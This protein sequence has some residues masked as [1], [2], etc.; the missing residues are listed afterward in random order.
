MINVQNISSKLASLPDQALKQY[1][2]MHKEDPYVFSLALSE[3][4]R[5]KQMR[6]QGQQAMPQ[7]RVVDKELEEMDMRL[8]EDLGIARIPIDMNMASGGIVAF[9]DGGMTSYDK[10]GTIRNAG[11]SNDSDAFKFAL[12]NTLKLEG[13]LNKNDKVGGLTKYGISQRAYPDLD[14]ANLTLADAK[15][16]YKKDYWNKIGGDQLAQKDPNLAALAFD[17]AVQHGV[18]GAQKMLAVSGNDPAKLLQVR[19]E[20]LKSLVEDNPE[21]YGKQAKGWS[22]R[23]SQLAFDLVP[24][25]TAVAGEMPRPAGN[26]AAPEGIAALAPSEVAATAPAQPAQPSA[27]ESSWRDFLPSFGGDKVSDQSLSDLVT[28]KPQSTPATTPEKS[29]LES[30]NEKAEYLMNPPKKS[31]VAYDPKTFRNPEA[32]AIQ[33]LYPELAIL[34]APGRMAAIAKRVLDTKPA[35]SGETTAGLPS[36]VPKPAPQEVPKPASQESPLA[37]RRDLKPSEREQMNMPPRGPSYPVGEEASTMNFLARQRLA[38]QGATKGAAQAEETSAAAAPTVVRN[39]PS[40]A[41]NIQTKMLSPSAGSTTAG[42]TT[43]VAPEEAFKPDYQPDTSRGY[44]SPA[45]DDRTKRDPANYKPEEKKQIIEAAKDAVPKSEDTDG[46]SKNDWLQFGLALMAGKSSN[47]LTNV[48]EAGLALLSSKQAR[49]L[50]N[51]E[52][53]MKNRELDIYKEGILNKHATPEKIQIAE[54]L[55]KEKVGLSFPDALEQA[56]A[57]VGG[58]TR[59]EKI[60]ADKLKEFQAAKNK[61]YD[62]FK[63]YMGG[64]GPAAKAQ[65]AEYQRKL[66]ELYSEYKMPMEAAETAPR[67]SPI[68]VLGVRPNP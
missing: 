47:A 66:K 58:A 60:S 46:W 67:G 54:R 18:T 11:S 29:W 3:S 26:V 2:E 4:N 16:I 44:P 21:K 57:L 24:A 41:Q 56:T 32:Q 62:G 23:L 40:V 65:Q 68:E 33:P 30:A 13:G 6:S 19:S 45:I 42:S 31:G 10:G 37:I 14:I 61:L 53:D 64:T 36:L 27:K 35:A 25:S 55:M 15:D 43:S 52:L 50:K 34:G 5:R 12:N 22:K 38:R 28:N 51:K 7:P 9:D 20:K 1:A 17:T 49:D 48:G 39:S 63:L 8:P 59:D